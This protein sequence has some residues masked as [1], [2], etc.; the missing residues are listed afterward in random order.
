MLVLVIVLSVTNVVTLGVLAWYLL[1]PV[2]HPRPDDALAAAIATRRHPS[3]AT[4]SA[5]RVITIEILNAIELAG[6]RGRLVGIAS[7]FVPGI[8]RRLVYDQAIRAVRQQLARERVVADVRLH[9]IEAD[10]VPARPE[11]LRPP[12]ITESA[13]ADPIDDLGPTPEDPRAPR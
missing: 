10:G 11:P 12:I 7:S 8:T 3:V 6:H 1:R 13:L 2:E 4:G 5:R 9:V